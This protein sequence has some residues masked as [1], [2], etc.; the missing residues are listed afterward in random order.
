LSDLSVTTIQRIRRG[1][2]LIAVMSAFF[3]FGVG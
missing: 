3:I 2:R 1:R